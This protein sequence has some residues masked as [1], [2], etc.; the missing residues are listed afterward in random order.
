MT[1]D[2]VVLNTDYSFLNIITVQRALRSVVVGKVDVERESSEYIQTSSGIF[3]KPLVV[4]VRHFVNTTYPAQV[5][6]S[7]HAVFIRDQFTCQYCGCTHRPLT[8]DHLYPLSRG[9]ES[10]FENTVSA[11]QPCNVKKGN[12][13]LEDTSLSFFD[14]NFTPTHPSVEDFLRLKLSHIDLSELLQ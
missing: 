11:C 13:T 9:G 6:W 12:D 1:D 8:I 4:R 5:S 3:H 14:E 10:T 7:R 2:V